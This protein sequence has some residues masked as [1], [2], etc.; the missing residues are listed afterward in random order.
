MCLLVFVRL[1]ALRV[2]KFPELQAYFS[3]GPGREKRGVGLNLSD[4]G[5]LLIHRVP[6]VILKF[7]FKK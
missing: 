3:V 7:E 6:P 2:S 4:Y 5:D 1:L